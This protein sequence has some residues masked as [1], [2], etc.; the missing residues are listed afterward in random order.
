MPKRPLP[1]PKNGIRTVHRSLYYWARKG[2]CSHRLRARLPLHSGWC[3]S[4]A[5]TNPVNPKTFV[6]ELHALRCTVGPFHL[7]WNKHG[8]F[9]HLLMINSVFVLSTLS[10]CLFPSSGW[11]F[12]RE[13]GLSGAAWPSPRPSQR[14]AARRGSSAAA[15]RELGGSRAPSS[16]ARDRARPPGLCQRTHVT[17][18][19]VWRKPGPTRLQPLCSWGF[20]RARESCSCCHRSGET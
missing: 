2:H 16:A 7:L 6:N 9:P 13:R 12:P 17:A 11:Q 5:N 18:I 20:W 1:P 10:V 15:G 14:D 8:P 3:L 19:A 4:E